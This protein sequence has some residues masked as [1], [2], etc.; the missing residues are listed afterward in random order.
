MRHVEV[1]RLGVG[2]EL[3]LLAYATATAMPDLSRVCDLHQQKRLAF[4][5]QGR[6]LQ[7]SSG[8]WGR[9]REGT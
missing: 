5:S 4:W 8:K 1:P 2:S 7:S 6:T 3:Q 9:G